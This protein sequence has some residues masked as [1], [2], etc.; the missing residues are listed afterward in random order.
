M[1]LSSY[2]VTEE[3]DNWFRDFNV[4]NVCSVDIET[5]LWIFFNVVLLN[6]TTTNDLLTDPPTTWPTDPTITDRPKR[7]CLKNSKIWKHWFYK[8]QTQL[9]KWKTIIYLNKIKGLL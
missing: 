9:E 7:L 5:V 4:L 8:M 6:P 3:I 2:Y 1:F